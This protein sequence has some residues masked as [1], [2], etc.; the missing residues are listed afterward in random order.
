M[1][2]VWGCYHSYIGQ[3]AIQTAAV[4]A[5]G[6]NKNLWLTT[7]RCHALA[8][9]LGMTLEEGMCELY[10]KAN[11]NASGRGGSMHL[12]TPNMFGG[13]GIVG[14]Q[15]PVGAGLAFSLKYRKKRGEISICFGGDGSVVQ[16]TF[17]ETMNIAKLWKIPLLIVI[18]NN[19]LGMGTQIER[20]IANL[21]IGE[22]LAK[23][24]NIK[25]YTLKG[26]NFFDLYQTFIEIGDFIKER[27]EPVI[28]EAVV[29][30]F[31]GHSISD[32]AQYR[33]KDDLKKIMEEDP[34]LFFLDHLRKA[35]I[36]TEEG[37]QKK[38]LEIRDRVMRAMRFADESPFPDPLTLET[39]VM[40]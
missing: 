10:G 18:E 34:I 21:P 19:Q 16:G 9:L 39:G 17:H 24:Y 31:R 5:L 38:N 29:Q 33:T 11:G 13:M 28:V 1:G 4:H 25:S 36:I 40:I 37:Y 23:A 30:R 2:K 14:G 26:D 22:N 15:W 35:G 7:Y 8:L 6:K 3:E 12:Y 32:A 27:Q 20:A